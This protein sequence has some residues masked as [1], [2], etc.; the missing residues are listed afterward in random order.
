AEG[1]KGATGAEGTKGTTGAEGTKGATGATGPT[2]PEGAKGTTGAEGTK[3]ATGAEGTKGATGAEGTKGTT[4]AEG[5]KGA[6][7]ATGP[8]GPG[9]KSKTLWFDSAQNA[10]SPN[11]CLGQS[12]NAH[13]ACPSGTAASFTYNYEVRSAGTLDSLWAEADAATGS[14]TKIWTVS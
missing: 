14:A 13:A 9:G 4:G 12:D 10:A 3:G 2:G 1:T 6:T 5:T 11:E 8:T 7:G